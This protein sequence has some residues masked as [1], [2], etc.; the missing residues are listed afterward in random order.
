LFELDGCLERLGELI[1]ASFR[2]VDHVV[3]I[4]GYCARCNRS[5]AKST[6]ARRDAGSPL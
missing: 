3:L 2:V 5:K 6:A 1:P 4:Y